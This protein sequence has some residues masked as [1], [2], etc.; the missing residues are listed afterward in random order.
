MKK[1]IIG[2]ALILFLMVPMTAFAATGTSSPKG[3][4][5]TTTKVGKSP[6]TGELPIALIVAVGSVSACAAAYTA[7][8]KEHA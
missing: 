6:K 5:I 1:A 3:E 4:T 8:K 2:L 7:R